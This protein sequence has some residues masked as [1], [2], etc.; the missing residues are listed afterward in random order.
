MPIL[1]QNWSV[2]DRPDFYAAPELR[3]KALVGIITWH[4]RLNV[5][6][7]KEVITSVI[8]KAEKGLVYTASGSVYKLG[9]VCQKY[10]KKY[11]GA[12]KRLFAKETI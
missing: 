5:D 1:I 12:R 6:Q 10:A 11:P 7:D 4:P 9:R 3:Q 2:T 8:V